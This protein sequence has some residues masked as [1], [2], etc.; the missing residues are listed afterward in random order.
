MKQL[1]DVRELS[2]DFSTPDGSLNAINKIDLQIGKGEIVCLVGESGSGKTITSKAIMR[3]TDYENGHITHG[4]ITLDGTRLTKLPAGEWSGLR[5]KRIS[6]VFQEPMTALDP[7]FTIGSQITE[8]ILRHEPVTKAQANAEAVS[9]L[10]RVG[11]PEPEIRAKQYPYEL[12]GGMRQ[13]AM[14][15]M[16]LACRPELLIADE[17]TTALD[18]TIQAQILALLRELKEEL[19]M[20]ILL[21][22]HDLGIAAEMADRIVVMYAGK[23]VEQAN[24]RQLFDN[25]AHPYTQ[26]LLH[27]I[28]T[29]DQVRGHRL[30]TIRGSIPSLSDLPSGCRFHPRCPYA[31]DRCRAEDPPLRELHGREVACWHAERLDHAAAEVFGSTLD[32]AAGIG[33]AAGGAGHGGGPKAARGLEAA[34]KAGL[35]SFAGAANGESAAT[36]TAEAP[37]QALLQVQGVK[38]YF[39]IQRGLLQRGKGAIRAVDD[40]TFDIRKG[41]TFGLVGESG[42]GKSTLGRVLLQLEKATAGRVVFEGRDLLARGGRRTKELRRDMQIVFQD[43][44]GSINPRWKV[45]DII[46]EPFWVHESLRGAAKREKVQ[47]VMQLVG[48]NPSWY[49][50]YPHEF[51]GGQRQRIGIARAIALSPKFVLADEAVSALDVSVQSQV[52]NLMQELQQQLQLTYLFIAHGLNIVRYISDRIGVMY[53]GKL[54][55]VA[56]TDELFRHPAHHYTHALLSAI[57]VPDPNRRKVYAPLQGEM[58]SPANPPSGCRFH[59]RCPAATALCRESAPELASVGPGHW[60]ACHYPV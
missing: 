38:K 27:S 24:V 57:P 59:T 26:G 49:E 8:V 51:S 14:I 21:I 7:V 19:N 55:E 22:T 6:M 37:G 30:Y 29:L 56:P 11:I 15:A 25:P 42:C 4:E 16:A 5:G 9:L 3:L 34:G 31:T 41:E 50:R 48:L 43:P 12:S 44:Y 54:V 35:S 28:V 47:Q 53:L 52:V 23:V 58:P 60:A 1:L 2:V 10:R 20:S 17:P 13:R 39:P 46:G 40:V 45:G 18:V 36:R 32:E 33:G